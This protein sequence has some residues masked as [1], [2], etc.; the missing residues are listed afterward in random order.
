MDMDCKKIANSAIYKK[1]NGLYKAIGYKYT[2]KRHSNVSS[3]V[4]T[5]AGRRKKRKKYLVSVG[6]LLMFG[7]EFSCPRWRIV[8]VVGVLSLA[9]TFHLIFVEIELFIKI[10][11]AAEKHAVLVL[12]LF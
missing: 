8:M 10:E 4:Y 9:T 5:F 2:T 11:R 12:N 3:L 1:G 7:F 6:N